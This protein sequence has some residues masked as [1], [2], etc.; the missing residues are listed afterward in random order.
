MPCVGVPIAFAPALGALALYGVAGALAVTFFAAPAG[1]GR[2]QLCSS[3]SA[4][5]ATCRGGALV[6]VVETGQPVS[7]SVA[8]MGRARDGSFADWAGRDR[9]SIET[10]DAGGAFTGP[11]SFDDRHRLLASARWTQQA[12][13]AG[14]LRRGEPPRRRGFSRGEDRSRRRRRLSSPAARWRWR[15]P[16]SR[17][18]CPSQLRHRRRPGYGRRGRSWVGPP[19]LRMAETTRIEK[20][21]GFDVTI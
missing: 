17:W 2:D 21:V 3:R 13:R 5:P 7:F 16:R 1:G 20:T 4:Q 14:I 12:A 19:R 15:A 18:R 8:Q 10:P 11:V 6:L 9:P